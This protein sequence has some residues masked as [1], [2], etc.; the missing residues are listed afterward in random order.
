MNLL[1]D[2][3]QRLLYA[4]NQQEE[5]EIRMACEAMIGTCDLE[6]LKKRCSRVHFQDHMV[7]EFQVDGTTI[8]RF[9]P[10]SIL[11]RYDDDEYNQKVGWT[12]KVERLWEAKLIADTGGGCSV[13]GERP[14]RHIDGSY[15]L[16]RSCEDN[17]R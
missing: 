7:D 13:C 17:V 10:P 12:R 11:W 15:W 6:V 5:I 4:I 16:C 9:W 2:I 14:C 8:L 1:A 3:K